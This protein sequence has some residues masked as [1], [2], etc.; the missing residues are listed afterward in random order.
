VVIAAT[1]ALLWITAL[2]SLGAAVAG[3]IAAVAAW[4]SAGAS[5]TASADARAASEDAREAVALGI[6]PSVVVRT[7]FDG[8]RSTS[9]RSSRSPVL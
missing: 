2:G 1:S 6:E 5:Q 4:K 9:C 8:S 7:G 3:A